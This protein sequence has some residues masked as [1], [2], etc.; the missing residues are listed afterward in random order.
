MSKL[1]T[2]EVSRLLGRIGGINRQ[3]LSNYQ[4]AVV[5]NNISGLVLSQCDLDDLG[6]CMDMKFGDWQLFRSAIQALK[7]A[8]DCPSQDTS[9]EKSECLQSATKRRTNSTNETTNRSIHF[10]ESDLVENVPS[11]DVVEPS[12]SRNTF[13]RQASVDIQKDASDPTFDVIEEEEEDDIKATYSRSTGSMKRNDSVVAEMMYESD[14]LHEFMHNF[15]ENEEEDEDD[16]SDEGTIPNRDVLEMHEMG[17]ESDTDIPG[18]FS[19]STEQGRYNDDEN[20]SYSLDIRETDPLITHVKRVKKSTSLG[21]P[22]PI[23]QLP[24][25][26]SPKLSQHPITMESHSEPDLLNLQKHTTT[27]LYQEDQPLLP[28]TRSLSTTSSGF[29]DTGMEVTMKSDD[30]MDYVS[31]VDETQSEESAQQLIQRVG[32]SQVSTDNNA[33]SLVIRSDVQFITHKEGNKN[34]NSPVNFV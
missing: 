12:R 32:T 1:S 8:E 9:T 19:L 7:D 27:S 6:K 24:V 3:Q 21:N 5:E 25:L 22:M 2:P 4:K 18:H 26:R 34:G 11:V 29:D 30:S 23:L 14:L 10:S 31:V 28:V 15:T 16:E 20:H 33:G 17:F 13:K